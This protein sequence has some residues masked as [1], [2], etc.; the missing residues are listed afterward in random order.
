MNEMCCRFETYLP[1]GYILLCW[2]KGF[3]QLRYFEIVLHFALITADKIWLIFGTFLMDLQICFVYLRQIYL[4]LD[5]PT[6][7][8]AF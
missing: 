5:S 4:L 1:V 2:T 7:G 8:Y 3:Q 6:A